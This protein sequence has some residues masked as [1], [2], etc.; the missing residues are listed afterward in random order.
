LWHRD[1]AAYFD[2]Q[3]ILDATGRAPSPFN[4]GLDRVPGPFWVTFF[5]LAAL[6]EFRFLRVR[7]QPGYKI[8]GDYGF[9]PLG[10]YPSDREGQRQ[11]ELAEIRNGRLA[12][13]A[14]GT[15]AVQEW[16][17][18][19]AIVELTPQFFKPAWQLMDQTASTSLPAADQYISSIL[20]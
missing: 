7:R 14:I 18:K 8:P 17:H 5:V 16:V 9:D 11:R 2:A 20:N 6:I 15:F 12:M 4:G 13:V 10:L 19:L 1:I 3:P